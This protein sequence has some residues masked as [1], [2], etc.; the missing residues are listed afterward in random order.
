MQLQIMFKG[1]Y[2]MV[3]D[4]KDLTS[5][6]GMDATLM[7]AVFQLSYSSESHP[8]P[9]Y[10]TG[11]Y[12]PGLWC[13]VYGYDYRNRGTDGVIS[14]REVAHVP[15]L[16]ARE[17]ERVLEVRQS[18]QLLLKRDPTYGLLD[19]QALTSMAQTYLD[20]SGKYALYGMI[21]E[22]AKY[23]GKWCPDK[24]PDDIAQLIAEEAA[25]PLSVVLA[26]IEQAASQDE[27]EDLDEEQGS[28]GGDRDLGAG[29]A[30]GLAEVD[31]E[32][33]GDWSD[34]EAY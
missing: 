3:I 24:G 2:P 5:P 16:S 17:L 32:G 9:K 8:E 15:V 26:A 12:A 11:D 18:G 19:L 27:G 10:G 21:A 25:L 7:A 33:G 6:A 22:L 20:E 31:E 14:L 1:A 29:E 28:P 13:H 23:F 4:T 34:D 30:E